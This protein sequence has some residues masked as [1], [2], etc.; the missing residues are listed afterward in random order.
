MAGTPTTLQSALSRRP[1]CLFETRR[2]IETRRLLE[3]WPQNQAFIRD[4]VDNSMMGGNKIVLLKHNFN[5]KRKL[6][7]K[8]ASILITEKINATC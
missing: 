7:H 3:H 5:I 8:Y 2:L 1:G 4:P 6:N